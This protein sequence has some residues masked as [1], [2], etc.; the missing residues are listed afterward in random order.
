[1]FSCVTKITITTLLVMGVIS[2]VAMADL[3]LTA[4]AMILDQSCKVTVEGGGNINMGVVSTAYVNAT[5]SA[6]QYFSGGKA[7]TLSVSDCGATR[8]GVAN[9][10][11]L[12]FAPQSGSFADAGDQTFI[13]ETPVIAGGASGTGIV[14]FSTEGPKNVL[15][16]GGN[17]NV[18]YPFP[19]SDDDAKYLFE[20]RFQK[21]S[22]AV[23]AGKVHSSVIVSAY[24]D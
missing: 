7:F 5:P 13:N 14:I 3:G 23:A 18:V 11:H 12:S 9:R 15:E 1:M 22:S 10:M 4:N 8:G 16:P 19:V 6:S 17:S 20:A 2:P 24:Y 21:I